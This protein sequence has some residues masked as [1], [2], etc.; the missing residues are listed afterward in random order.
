MTPLKAEGMVDSEPYGSLPARGRWGVL[1]RRRSRATAVTY[2]GSGLCW[3]L[4]V[5]CGFLGTNVLGAGNQLPFPFPLSPTSTRLLRL[6]R[7]FRTWCGHSVVDC[8]TCSPTAPGAPAPRWGWGAGSGAGLDCIL[9][10][11]SEISRVIYGFSCF[12]RL[13]S[14][15]C[16]LQGPSWSQSR[17]WRDRRR[18]QE[19]LDSGWPCAAKKEWLMFLWPVICFPGCRKSP[20]WVRSHGQCRGN[21]PSSYAV[22]LCLLWAGEDLGPIFTGL[23]CTKEN[24]IVVN[25]VVSYYGQ[26]V[27]LVVLLFRGVQTY[28]LAQSWEVGLRKWFREVNIHY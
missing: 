2:G 13:V 14:G 6:S 8:L 27:L 5:R 17:C 19:A 15:D 28:K 21:L 1:R 3:E 18:Y 11:W 22:S 26:L 20:F 7:S 25:Q 9:E 16:D 4:V 23:L 24:F 12:P 10:S